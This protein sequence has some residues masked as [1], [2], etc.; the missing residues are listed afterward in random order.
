MWDAER[1]HGGS[2][3]CHGRKSYPLEQ[4]G[5]GANSGR[6]VWMGIM[7]G[8]T[9][10]APDLFKGR[11]FDRDV[12]VLCVRWYLSFKLSS[13]DL[14]QMMSERGIALAHTTILRW[15]QRYVPDF[16][17]RWTQYARSV[18]GSW[19]CD[20]TYIKVKGRWTYLYR[21]VD[22]QGR[23]VDFLLSERRDV[24]AAKRFFRNAIKNNG[25]PRVVTLDAY[26]ASHRAIGELKS[27][28]TLPRRVR[29]RSSK[30]LNNVVEQDHRRIKQ[31]IRPML[32]FKRFDTAAV[33]I[34]GIE[35]AQKIKKHQF[36][37]G[38]LSGRP[39]TAPEIW[40]AVLAA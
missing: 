29:I 13:R 24:A 23:T 12:I 20:E 34:T 7:A 33:A 36:K 38:K 30:Y 10:S 37:I 8:M 11:H 14:V 32:G 6:V 25:I 2:L 19:R 35:L 26:A 31:R 4:G 16:E 27:V 21:A 22:K 18:G 17:K 3:G 9:A 28:G 39:R 5:S 40:A 1:P 15:V